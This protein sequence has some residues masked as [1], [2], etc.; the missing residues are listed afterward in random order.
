MD[1]PSMKELLHP[2]IGVYN[3]ALRF[4]FTNITE[5]EFESAW[6][7][8]PIKIPAG[9]TVE[10]SHHLAVKLTKEIVD[11]IMIGEAK[12]DEVANNKGNPYYRSPKGM[13][14]GIPSAR[15]VWEK[16][17]VR[18]LDVDEESPEMQTVRSKIREELLSDFEASKQPTSSSIQLPNSLNEFAD[19]NKVNQEAKVEEKKRGRPPLKLK[20]LK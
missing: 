4:A 13:S 18:L 3:P 9:K 6:G 2:E 14:L 12:L 20:E 7:G 15:E 11:K 16:K 10:L 17:V 19:I 1:T 8:Q 5:E